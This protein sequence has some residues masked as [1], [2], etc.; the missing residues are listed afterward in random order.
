[1]TEF[2]EETKAAIIELCKKNRVRELSLF[3]SRARGDERPDSDFDILVDFQPDSGIDL[4]DYAK[5]QIDLEKVIGKKVDLVEKPGLKKFVRDR[6]L[7]EA[8][9]I[10]EG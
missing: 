2:S 3:G 4:F 7:A 10:Y 6:V 9:L 1:M 5:M 8:R